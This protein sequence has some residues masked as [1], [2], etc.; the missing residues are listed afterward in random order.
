MFGGGGAPPGGGWKA[1]LQNKIGV[2][3]PPQAP[4][5]MGRG[6]QDPNAPFQGPQGPPPQLSAPG[7]GQP[8]YQAQPYPALLWGGG[9]PLP[10]WGPNPVTGDARGPSSYPGIRGGDNPIG[11]FAMP[12]PLTPMPSGGLQAPGSGGGGGMPSG[13]PRPAGPP[14]YGPMGGQAYR[15]PSGPP[16]PPQAPPGVMDALGGLY[17][18]YNANAG[19]P[20]PGATAGLAAPSPFGPP[21]TGGAPQAPGAP[22]SNPMQDFLDRIK[23]GRGPSVR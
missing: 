16:A 12:Q 4:P 6:G 23:A 5:S 8:P 13:P 21:Q 22:P 7:G 18:T 17:G 19:S 10:N 15:P 14:G 3:P 11:N 20:D 9:N 2:Q 1:A